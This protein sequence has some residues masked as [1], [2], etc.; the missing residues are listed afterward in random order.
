MQ[1]PS[2]SRQCA[3]QIGFGVRDHNTELELRDLSIK[4]NESDGRPPYATDAKGTS[5]CAT[6]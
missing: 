3:D 4:G 6:L 2:P 1:P 5:S